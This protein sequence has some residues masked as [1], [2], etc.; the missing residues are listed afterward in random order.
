LEYNNFFHINS[1]LK[2]IFSGVQ[3]VGTTTQFQSTPDAFR[4]IYT[5]CLFISLN[6]QFAILRIMQE[7]KQ[8]KILEEYGFKDMV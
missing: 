8:F 2:N 3:A 5:I 7:R 6:L 1:P 4:E